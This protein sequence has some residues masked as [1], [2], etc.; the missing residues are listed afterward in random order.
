MTQQPIPHN[1]DQSEH[2]DDEHIPLLAMWYQTR[3]ALADFA[4]PVLAGLKVV[5]L[6]AFTPTKYFRAYLSHTQHLTALRTPID[7]FWRTFTPEERL[8][9]DAAKFL[10]FAILTAALAGFPFDN[11]NRISGLIEESDIMSQGLAVLQQQI[12]ALADVTARI[13][14]FL[15]NETVLA[16][17]EFFDQNLIS[18]VIELFVTL[19]LTMLFAYLFR[20]LAG[21]GVTATGSY[22]F[23]L[24]MTGMQFFTKAITFVIFKFVSLP[25]F[26]LPSF[27]PQSIFV[28]VEYAWTLLWLY[29]LP[30]WVLPRIF[31]PLTR[32]R[33]LAALLITH[34]VFTG[35]NW[36]MSV[37]FATV[38][39]FLSS[40]MARF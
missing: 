19:I 39:L 11:T 12:P 24:Y 17:Q 37:G 28:I 7:F 29:L 26:D 36:L 9:L 33:T 21:R 10:L 13:D 40:L 14:L 27:M 38:L 1:F 25:A 2:S 3:S 8:P 32:S 35:I 15:Q 18:A 30:L 16:I 20:L 22:A 5:W 6:I 23:W 4:I 34:A 31:P